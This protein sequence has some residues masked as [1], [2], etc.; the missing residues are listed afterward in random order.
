MGCASSSPEE[1][2]TAVT[3]ADAGKQIDLDFDMSK[4]EQAQQQQQDRLKAQDASSQGQVSARQTAS[5][6][7]T[8]LASDRPAFTQAFVHS[9]A[10]KRAVRELEEKYETNDSSVLGRGACGSVVAVRHRTTGELFAMKV[11]SLETVGGSLEE[12]RR[13]IEIQKTLDHP[14]ICKI[15]ESYEDS[16]NNEVFIIMEICTGGSLVSRMKHHKHGYGERAA[17]TLVEKIL[18]S[19]LYCHHHGVVHRDIKLDN[20]IYE[21]E[22]E[23]SELK[24]ID[25]GFACEIQPGREAMWDQLGTPSYM[26]PEL[27]SQSEVEYDSSVDMWAIG[28]V[29]YMLLS[30]KRPFHHQDKR[31]KARMIRHDPLK[32]PSPEWDRISDEAQNFCTSLMQKQPK[33]R[34]SATAAKDHPWIKHA[35]KLHQGETA[36]AEM[37]HHQDVVDSLQAF[38][39][40]D[41]LK[42]L[43]LEVIAFETPPSKLEELR[44]LFVKMDVDDSGTISRT[45]FTEAMRLHPEVPEEMIAKMYAEMDVD[46]SGEVDYTEF[47][48]ATLSA[49]KHSNASMIS[50]FNTLDADRDGYITKEDL[51]EALDGQMAESEIASMLS[52][53]DTTGKVS[54][55]VFKS[56]LLSGMKSNSKASPAAVVQHIA[57][58]ERRASQETSIKI[59]P[60]QLVA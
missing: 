18:S 34:L 44:H 30:G 51:V 24:L 39:E 20:F 54:F 45:E 55:S 50:A 38:A 17:A 19:I 57:S 35:S 33:D 16:V 15:F 52:K 47:L 28:V 59:A 2:A 3:E 46:K 1:H 40:A 14:N 7:Q 32:F 23:E 12:L 9:H 6:Y 36:A 27:W 48:S 42:K 31:E 10:G 49:Q 5:G 56:I 58:K 22:S 4:L 37:Q 13:E 26:A 29:T 25:F 60:T 43:A 53:A 8:D 41:E 21:N 11:V